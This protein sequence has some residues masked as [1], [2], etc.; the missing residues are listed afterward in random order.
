LQ[1]EIILGRGKG[2]KREVLHGFPVD[3]EAKK[4]SW[5]EPTGGYIRK[6][7][8]LRRR[9]RRHGSSLSVV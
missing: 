6:W 8:K 9:P 3:D 7:A 4:D 5:G 2:N 1:Q